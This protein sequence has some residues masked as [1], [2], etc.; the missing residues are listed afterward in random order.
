MF[1]ERTTQLPV[2]NW[3]SPLS[4]AFLAQ[5]GCPGALEDGAEAAER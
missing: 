3:Q 1:V 2:C 5:A 4:L